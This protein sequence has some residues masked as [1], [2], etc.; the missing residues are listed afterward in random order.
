MVNLETTFAGLTLKNPFVAAS[1]GLTNSLS[2][3]KELENAGIGAVVLKSLFEEQIENHTEK[4]TQIADYP[5][6]ADYIN[7]YIQMNH[8]EKYLDLIRSAKASCSI[9][10]VASINCYRLTR[11]TD[12]AK[13]IEAAGADAIELNIFLLNAGEY[14]DTYLEGA[15][16][17]IV[18]QLKRTVKIPVVVKMARNI[19]NLPGLVGKLK[20]LG[21]DGIV[22]FN[23]FY[24][25][26]I[27]I[28][29]L[30]LTAGT[31]FSNPADFHDTLRWTAIV[32]GRVKDVDIACSTGVHSW[33]D[34]IKGILAGASGIQL[35]SVLYEQG[36]DVVGDMITCVEEWMV[37]NNYERISDF[38]GKLNYANITSPALY[39]RVQFMKYFS[40]Y[41]Q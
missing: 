2:K 40:S 12:F 21:S 6:A 31:V 18:K 23:R 1:S 33:E 29:K 37:Q 32:S 17:D 14:E 35:C 25:L 24:Q 15:Y 10:I 11:W 9:P 8:V 30:E 22:L 20:A 19:G 5:E 26:D 16:I 36:L 41:Q 13:S 4:L 3:I 39:E 34:S 27:D 28:N 7:A 38:R